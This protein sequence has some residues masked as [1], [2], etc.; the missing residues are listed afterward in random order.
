[1]SKSIS[2]LG[3]GWLG[4]PLAE[5]LTQQGYQVKGTTTTENKLDILREKGISPY[6]AMLNP[7]L[8]ISDR[9]FFDSD[10]LIINIPPSTLKKGPDYHPRQITSL[11]Q[12]LKNHTFKKIFYVSSTSV[13]PE[14]N[15]LVD[16][17]MNLTAENDRQK[18]LLQAE[19]ELQK[20]ETGTIILRCG[21]LMGYD[22][23][24]TK[25]LNMNSRGKSRKSPDT[26]VNY[27]H[28]DDVVA[29]IAMLMEK[30]GHSEIFNLVAPMHPLRKEFMKENMEEANP[31]S[32][33]K[34]V[35]SEKIVQ[36]LDYKFKYP[37][38][39]LFGQQ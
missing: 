5:H 34:I 15:G 39:L 16:E 35:S 10:I 23:Q 12:N 13:Y 24:P 27:I 11:V 28:R 18:A 38:P 3:C 29:I 2:I 19:K 17:R 30:E 25:F 14:T 4:L 6:L 20:P 26:P 22:R 1:M 7:E 21:G 37:D 33:Y 8:S 32:S 36:F 31:E 9:S